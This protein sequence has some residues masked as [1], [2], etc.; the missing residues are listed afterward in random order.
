MKKAILW[1][2]LA[3]LSFVM[4]GCGSGD[5]SSGGT[6]IS[7]M[8]SK[9]PISG[10]KV[11]IFS[12]TTSANIG[13]Q[14]AT[15]TTAANGAFSA[16][17]GAYTGAIFATMSG[18]SAT[19]TDEATNTAT[20]LGTTKL[21]AAAVI[22]ASGPFNLAITPLTELAYQKAAT[23]RAADITTANTLIGS[24]FMAGTDIV[25]TLPTNIQKASPA[26]TDPDKINY[27][28]ALA[29]FSQVLA[30]ANA[31]TPG[32]LDVAGA[33]SLLKSEISGTTLTSPEWT[34]TPAALAANTTF[35][36]NFQSGLLTAPVSIAFSSPT[37]SAIINQAIP[38]TVK[39]TKFDGSALSGA[40]VAF[41]TSNGTLGASAPTDANGATT[42]TLTPTIVGQVKVSA[43][44]TAS[45]VT[46]STK[47]AAVVT[48]VRDPND[49]GTVTLSSSSSTAV[50]NQT[51][52]LTAKVG[53]V[54]GGPN[55]VTAGGPPPVGTA[56]T[57][58]IAHGTGTLTSGATSSP[59]SVSAA[60][61]ANGN[62]TVTLTSATAGSITLSASAGTSPVVPSNPLTVA[63][64][65]DP[66][67]PATVTVSASSSST[68]ADGSSAIT[69][70][71]TVKN[72][73]G[74][75]L[76][77]VPLTFSSTGGGTLSATSGA[78]DANG[79]ATVSMTSST[80]GSA[81]LTVVAT[82][83]GASKS[84]TSTVS[85]TTVPARP[86]TA[87]VKV[88]TAGTFSSGTAI[89]SID[90]VVTFPSSKGLTL[91][92]TNGVVAS[93]SATVSGTTLLGNVTS[94]GNLTLGLT[95]ATGIAL[96]EFGTLTFTIPSSGTLPVA[97]DFA[98]AS[99]AAVNNAAAVLQPNINVSILS[100]TFQ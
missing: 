64:T 79:Q 97:G 5:F 80:I 76:P 29:R 95:N 16:N 59:S 50:V 4:Y 89:G 61:D 94:P 11:A 69:F 65:P 55:N 13:R 49:P 60:T 54:G 83:S 58:T 77:S 35:T 14:L 3:F 62:A 31:T 37:Y 82:A 84:G 87:I 42:V 23:L 34:A 2:M 75:A 72:Y 88:R 47:T 46:A 9:G 91:A 68:P 15:G 52:T 70:T 67:A 44:A 74:T 63:F 18:S 28:L 81:T 96:G 21:H 30:T 73:A 40:S 1:S 100:V 99:G 92:S 8:A 43:S 33:I 98:V 93:G 39:V 38:V 45:G 56:V 27:S 6:T 22:T 10:A 57:F 17:L 20:P 53:V 90:A 48:V 36:T 25:S 51:M 71:V 32:S 12:V 86:T 19:Y 85:F 7:G 41:T 66:A 26:A 24:L 78:T